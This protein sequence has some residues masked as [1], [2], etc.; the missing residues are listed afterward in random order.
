MF[1][2]FLLT[3]RERERKEINEDKKI[4]QMMNYI[5][6]FCFSYCSVPSYIELMRDKYEENI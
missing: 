2:Y 3:E 1:T 4:M 6:N 5:I